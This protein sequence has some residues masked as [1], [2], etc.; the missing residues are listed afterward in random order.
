[1]LAPTAAEAAGAE[2]AAP[3]EED[4]VADAG[5]DFEKPKEKKK[6][7]QRKGGGATAMET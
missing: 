5:A 6:Q 3:M 2:M 1:M 7:Q 4:S